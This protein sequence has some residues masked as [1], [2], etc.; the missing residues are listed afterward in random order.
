MLSAH[1]HDYQRMQPG[2]DSTYQVIAGNGGSKGQ[3]AFFGYSTINVYSSGKVQLV[4]KGFTKGNPYYSPTSP[5]APF[6]I[7]DSTY[8]T[9]TPNANPYK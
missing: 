4:S 7:K 6:D 8:L 2:G 9:F 3:A 1:V 5:E